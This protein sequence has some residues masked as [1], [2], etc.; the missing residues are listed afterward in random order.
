MTD[1]GPQL[2]RLVQ[3]A[4]ANFDVRSTATNR[5]SFAR[6][7]TADL[8]Q[9]A[10]PMA[11]QAAMQG[12]PCKV[13]NHRLQ[14]VQAVVQGQQGMVAKGDDYRLLLNRSAHRQMRHVSLGVGAK[15]GQSGVE[16]TNG[17]QVRIGALVVV[18]LLPL[19]WLHVSI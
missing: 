3:L 5:C 13:R 4:K 8:G 16:K 2:A 14:S 10:D 12:R 11:L 9:S 15:R 7:V 19:K 17:D 1:F 6:L 18:W